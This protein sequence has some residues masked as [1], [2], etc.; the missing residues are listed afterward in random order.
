MRCPADAL[1][2]ID[3][4]SLTRPGMR[5][6][7]EL[8][9]TAQ[10]A[11][12]VSCSVR[13]PAP[14]H[15]SSGA[16]ELTSFAQAGCPA[17]DDSNPWN[18]HFALTRSPGHALFCGAL[19]L[20]FAGAGL[21]VRRQRGHGLL[22]EFPRCGI[23][24]TA[25]RCPHPG[26]HPGSSPGWTRSAIDA[27]Q[28]SSKD[29]VY[30]RGRSTESAPRVYVSCKNGTVAPPGPP[31]CSSHIQPGTVGHSASSDFPLTISRV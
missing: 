1:P 7:R 8:R 11:V 29:G 23:R 4:L 3:G 30:G 21:S 28:S 6:K 2:R 14:R 20:A 15:L 18:D 5:A 26:I 22:H 13:E 27:H 31:H 16:D 9:L 25:L 12:R 10:I 19:G 17:A 24:V